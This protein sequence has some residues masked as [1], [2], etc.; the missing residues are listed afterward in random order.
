MWHIADDT[1]GKE[2]TMLIIGEK[3]DKKW[4]KLVRFE[5]GDHLDYEGPS[6]ATVNLKTKHGLKSSTSKIGYPWLCGV[7]FLGRDGRDSF[8]CIDK[9]L[10]AAVLE[11]NEENASSQ[12]VQPFASDADAQDYIAKHGNKDPN[13]AD[14]RDLNNWTVYPENEWR[15][16]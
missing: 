2:E 8:W 11:L 7:L 16:I 6:Y 1:G 5:P 3:K 4:W 13:S 9:K 10:V 15:S 14:L 12:P